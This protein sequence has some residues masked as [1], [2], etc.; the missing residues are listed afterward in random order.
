MPI[1]TSSL[2]G[3]LGS[4]DAQVIY[5]RVLENLRSNTLGALLNASA[6]SSSNGKTDIFR[7]V[8]ILATKPYTWATRNT[9][10]DQLKGETI[11]L[12]KDQERKVSFEFESF[13][14]VNA[15]DFANQYQSQAASSIATSIRAELDAEF[16]KYTYNV[17]VANSSFEINDKFSTATTDAEFQ[18]MVL[19]VSDATSNI[20]MKVD[21]TKVGTNKNLLLGITSLKSKM[22]F[23]LGAKAGNMAEMSRREGE[24]TKIAGLDMLDHIFILNNL[25]AN[26]SFAFDKAYDFSKL[27][28][29]IVHEGAI[30]MGLNILTPA[31]N[32]DPNSGNI[33]TVQ[34]FQYGLKD[35]WPELVYMITNATPTPLTRASVQ[36]DARARVLDL[37][38]NKPPVLSKAE[39]KALEKEK[40]EAELLN[41]PI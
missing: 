35:L 3:M 9:Q 41:K 7:K 1:P 21:K 20:Q 5:N 23:I 6:N 33:K 4:I 14:E 17:C 32:I 16:I 30:A 15:G 28:Y 19:D 37:K 34:K 2:M 8:E 36:A 22:R 29:M 12:T 10:P 26:Q 18:K 13:D 38:V 39:K 31:T 25:T 40:K 11:Y 24:I 27:E